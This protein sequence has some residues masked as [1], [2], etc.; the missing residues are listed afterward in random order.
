MALQRNA[1]LTPQK[2]TTAALLL[3]ASEGIAA[4]SI[5]RLA[6]EL[7]VT[8]GSA[9]H[10]F[11]SRNELVEGALALWEH[12]ATS[13]IIERLA[14]V[15]SPTERLR[16]ILAA[17]VGRDPALGLEFAIISSQDDLAAPFVERV[18]IA[19]VEF[20]EQIYRDFGLDEQR[21]AIWA[22][23]AY[24]S[25]LGVQ[26]LRH[27]RATDAVVASIGSSYI[28]ELMVQLTPTT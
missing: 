6:A 1:R 24:S 4:V 12:E 2:W 19:R 23:S 13:A 20:L 26:L 18:T 17:S 11:G 16:A 8:K 15:A 5:E 14:P 27:G 3:M 28:D 22:R 9:Y 10:H 25:Y 21:A 7:G